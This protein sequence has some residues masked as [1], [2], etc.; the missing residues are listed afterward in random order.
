MQQI[1]PARKLVGGITYILTRD[2]FVY[3]EAVT[4]LLLEKD[5]RLRYGA[6]YMKR[7]GAQFPAGGCAE[8]PARR[9][10]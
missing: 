7:F 3:P 6:P 4:G 10:E 2:G 1:P 5:R 8:L 9:K